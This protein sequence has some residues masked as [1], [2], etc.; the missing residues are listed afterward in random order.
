[1]QQ[2]CTKL[3]PNCAGDGVINTTRRRVEVHH[4]IEKGR[5]D[6][7]QRRRFIIKD[8]TNSYPFFFVF[9]VIIPELLNSLV[10]LPSFLSQILPIVMHKKE[11]KRERKSYGCVSNRRQPFPSPLFPTTTTTTSRR[12]SYIIKK[13]SSLSIR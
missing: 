4:R 13:A 12:P 5:L 9:Y 2:P 8:V 3:S 1:M 11:E 7:F 6:R 10:P